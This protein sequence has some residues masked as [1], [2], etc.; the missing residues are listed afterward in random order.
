[1]VSLDNSWKP[2]AMVESETQGEAPFGFTS[3]RL[4]AQR[5]VMDIIEPTKLENSE[6]WKIIISELKNWGQV[7][8]PD[9]LSII[10]TK[11]TERGL[12]V[13]LESDGINWIAEFLPWGSDGRLQSR[14]ANSHSEMNIPSGGY[15]WNDSD[16]II[17]RKS[18]NYEQKVGEKLH[19]SLTE[20]NFED[21]KSI[22]HEAGKKLG[23][24]H[25]SIE[26]ARITPVD[27]QRWNKRLTKL[28]EILK[29]NT[30]WR[31]PFTRDTP[32]VLSLGDV[33]FDDFL[34]KEN[35]LFSLG[36][37]PPRLADGLFKDECEFPAIRDFA[38]L[39]HDLSRIYHKS[40][41]NIDIILLRKSLIDGWISTAPEKWCSSNAFYAHRGG[42][43]IWEYEQSLLD[44]L[45]AF[46]RQSGAPEPAVSI[47]SKVIPF[48][49][50]MYSN[51]SP[52]AVAFMS[53]FLG[54]ITIYH[55]TPTTLSELLMPAFCITVGIAGFYL[56]RKASPS[57][58]K[59]IT[60]F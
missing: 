10:S 20:N 19:Q 1:M 13:K 29:S 49:K 60:H 39:M 5:I 17:L 24:Y 55:Q 41:S 9:T 15:S 28:E 7:P 12:L 16:I 26:S 3:V 27:Q 52:A 35:G 22:L 37:N 8:N 58:T 50:K 38:C 53:F 45:E 46:A 30:I 36:I 6:D 42:L 48:Q 31:A 2:S 34:I 51:R 32:C 43:V 56:Y 4:V 40:N 33:R 44:V 47:I 57:P 18:L 59:P 25:S 23:L 21:S 14:V 11:N 54:V